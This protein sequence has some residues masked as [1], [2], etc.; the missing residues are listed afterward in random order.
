MTTT[1]Q[2]AQ[3]L[4]DLIIEHLTSAYACTRVWSAWQ[5]GTM[6][7]NDFVPLSETDFAQDLAQDILAKLQAATPAE[8]AQ[9]GSASLLDG[10]KSVMDSI[11]VSSSVIEHNKQEPVQAVELPKPRKVIEIVSDHLTALGADG[12]VCPDAECACRLGELAPCDSDFGGCQPG[13]IGLP[14]DPSQEDWTMWTSKEK[15]DH[16]NAALS[17]KGV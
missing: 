8:P 1:P 11:A 7:E 15:S 3:V 4:T 2:A 14:R 17:G 12:L 6:S 13:W 10:C 9:A 5:V 16:E